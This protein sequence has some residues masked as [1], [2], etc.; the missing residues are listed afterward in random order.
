MKRFDM[1]MT[2]VATFP[3]HR[4]APQSPPAWVDSRRLIWDTV[5]ELRQQNL[6]ADER[7]V[8]QLLAERMEHDD[9]L[10]EAGAHLLAHDALVAERVHRQ[11]STSAPTPKQRVAHKVATA[12]A[13]K[14]LAQKARERIW[15]DLP[16]LLL[17]GETKQLRYVSGR[18][19]A[20]L[21]GAYQ[22]IAERVGPDNFVGE[23]MVE[24]EVK[25]LLQA[26][27]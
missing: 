24:S 8:A 7:R 15:L 18:E 5:G 21:G 1:S 12:K 25:A 23:V 16:I 14:Q 27:V 3:A 20:E 6:K 4:S 2:T 11:R 17:S 10:R 19:L 9:D 13:V 22:A 26:A